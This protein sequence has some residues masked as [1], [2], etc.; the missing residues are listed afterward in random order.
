MTDAR[1]M[2]YLTRVIRHG[3][4]KIAPRKPGPI[5]HGTSTAYCNRGCR[6]VACTKF[7]RDACREYR[8]RPRTW[9]DWAHGR[10][11]SYDHGCRCKKCRCA[12]VDANARSR[13]KFRAARLAAIVLDRRRQAR[14]DY[15]HNRYESIKAGTWA[16]GSKLATHPEQRASEEVRR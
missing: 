4:P 3:K 6:C 10:A 15:L 1:R 8:H 14:R 7:H 2:G 9:P 5:V 13:A 11:T 12:K 16:V